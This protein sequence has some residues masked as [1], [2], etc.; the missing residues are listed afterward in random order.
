MRRIQ[1][2]A[3]IHL[4]CKFGPEIVTTAIIAVQ[5]R[6]SVLEVGDTAWLYVEQ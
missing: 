1:E 2:D 4:L 3:R 6:E 5:W